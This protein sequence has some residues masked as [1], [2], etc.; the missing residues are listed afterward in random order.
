VLY[1]GPGRDTIDAGG[2][3]DHVHVRDG[4]RDI[5]TCGTNRNRA[6]ERD[7]VWADR[8]DDIARDCERVYRGG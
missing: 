2:G 6:S 5:V 3:R 4:R 7:E 8:Y 1:G